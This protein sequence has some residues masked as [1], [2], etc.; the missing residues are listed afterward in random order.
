M[1]EIL[2]LTSR[3][4]INPCGELRLIKNRTKA[5]FNK[6]GIRTTFYAFINCKKLNRKREDIGAESVLNV[7]TYNLAS[8]VT[9]L[10]SYK[11]FKKEFLKR[12]TNDKNIKVVVVSSFIP[13]AILKELKRIRSDI[14]VVLDIHGAYEELLEYPKEKLKYGLNFVLYSIFNANLQRCLCIADAAFVVSKAL[15]KYIQE[16]YFLK[17]NFKFYIVPCGVNVRKIDINESLNKRAKWREFFG[18]E[19]DDVVFVYSGGVSKW[20]M[21]NE[22]INLYK[23]IK[24]HISAKTKLLILSAN[25]DKI[26]EIC[27]REKDIIMESFSPETVQD[28]LFAGDVAFLLREDKTTNNVAFPNKFAE[29]VTS[30]LEVICSAALYDPA[31]FTSE[32]NVGVVYKDDFEYLCEEL[33]KRIFSRAKDLRKI[34]EHRNSI[35]CQL[36]FSN[37]LTDFVNDLQNLSK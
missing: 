4:I 17:S 16:K 33:K 36:N 10:I 18:I 25:V 28:V 9:S 29:Y 1:S 21:I 6:W 5:L 7:Y 15:I 27:K 3:N 20:Q 30:G 14:Y 34:Y 19:K 22:T 11:K 13:V 24:K 31:T 37:T 35:L 2:F 26:K 8:P 23:K 12:V 32:N